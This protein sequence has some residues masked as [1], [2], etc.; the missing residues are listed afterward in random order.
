MELELRNENL[1]IRL[2]NIRNENNIK[3]WLS[4]YFNDN[5]VNQKALKV[6]LAS[7]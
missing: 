6:C 3:L 2:R 1:I 4:P 7:F 5:Q